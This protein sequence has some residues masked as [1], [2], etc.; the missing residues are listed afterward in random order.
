MPRMRTGTATF[1]RFVLRSGVEGEDWSFLAPQTQEDPVDPTV[2]DEDLEVGSDHISDTESIDTRGGIS[3]AAGE[4]EV[5]SLLEAPVPTVSVPVERFTDS[6]QWLRK[7]I[8]KSIQT[9]SV[10]D[11]IRSRIHEGGV[12]VGHARCVRRGRG[13]K[14]RRL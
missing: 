6:F 10:S 11:E 3:D 14:G 8:W 7:W 9:P 2:S 12:S 13:G 5:V 1:L 4:A